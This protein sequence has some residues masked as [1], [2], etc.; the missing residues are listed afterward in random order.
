[1]TLKDARWQA[2]YALF[3]LLA[4]L[5]E[6]LSPRQTARL[7]EGLA[8]IF[9]RVLPH[10]WTRYDV[11]YENIR[12]AFEA[13]HVSPAEIDDLIRG[14][15]V[16][17]FRLV[18]EV[19][20]FPR[21]FRL[22]NC[23]D[24]IVFRNRRMAV[25][26][27]STGRP[28]FVLGGHFGN[29]EASTATFGLFGFPLGIVARK[30]DNPYLHAWFLAAREKTGHRLLLKT[31]GWDGMVDLLNAGGNLGLLCDQDAGKRGVFVNF[32]GRPA[33]THRSI[34]L[35]ALEYK[36][37]VLVGYGR[38]LPDDFENSRWARFEI[39]CEAVIDAA[40]I[41]A[42]DEVRAL[43][44]Q[45]SQALQRS[46]ERSPEQYFWVHRRWKT[47]PPPQRK[48]HARKAAG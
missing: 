4:C 45:I 33:S 20:Q 2:E 26:A 3:R 46:V 5:V 15:W 21:K 13:R 31:G 10:R 39:G 14:M 36:A 8:W 42:A 34:A 19:I 47:L 7:A 25:Q 1:M 43:T 30:L 22:E 11:A 27:L 18:A 41:Q 17:L 29:W 6:I 12:L 37:L 48:E 44:E 16:H 23:R 24:I 28:V 9:V 35:M 38:R 32:F 40:S